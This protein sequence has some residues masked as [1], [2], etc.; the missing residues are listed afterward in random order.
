M[1]IR[2]K[3]NRIVFFFSKKKY[4]CCQSMVLDHYHPKYFRKGLQNDRGGG[5]KILLSSFFHHDKCIRWRF[6]NRHMRS[7]ATSNYNEKT[8]NLF[9]LES[10][11]IIKDDVLLGNGN[12]IIGPLTLIF[13]IDATAAVV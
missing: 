11:T 6:D 8:K 9:I 4:Q 2:G 7:N 1:L 10:I 13:S 3:K 5:L 12:D